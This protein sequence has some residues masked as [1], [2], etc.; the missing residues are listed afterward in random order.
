MCNNFI[1]FNSYINTR[2]YFKNT[3]KFSQISSKKTNNIFKPIKNSID[4]FITIN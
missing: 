2:T 4:C 1:M 3:I